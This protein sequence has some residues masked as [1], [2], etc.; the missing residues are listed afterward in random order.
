M[1]ATLVLAA[2]GAAAVFPAP[3][4]YRYTAS[5]AGQSVGSWSVT[6]TNGGDSTTIAEESRAS[7]GGLQLAATASLVLGPDLAPTRYDGHYRTPGQN[8]NVSVVLTPSAATVVGAFNTEPQQVPLGS[9]TR[10]FVVIE[11]GLLAGLFAL[12]AQL[13]SWKDP[14]VTWI[15]PTTAQAQSLTVGAQTSARPADVPSQ[16]ALLSIDRPI[17]VTIWY[18]PSTLVPDEIVVPSQN[19]VLTRQRS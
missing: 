12:P 2:L 5:M 16:D 1:L 3:G 11:P 14:A 19:A 10:H 18:D 7:I 6:V 4:A 9:N 17:A 15:T 8:P 13:R